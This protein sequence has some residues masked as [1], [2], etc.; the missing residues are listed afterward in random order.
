MVT[1]PIVTSESSNNGGQMGI[2]VTQTK[3]IIPRRRNDLLTRERLNH[4]LDDLLDYKLLLIAAPAGYGKTSLLIDWVHQNNLPVCWF[5]LDPLDQDLARFTSHLIASIRRVFPEFGQQSQSALENNP[6]PEL[7]I[8][9]VITSIVNDAFTNIKEHFV[10]VLDDFHAI[11]SSEKIN[12]F[13]SRFV[14]EVDENCHIVL[15][16]RTLLSLPNL[17]LMVGR[18]MVKGLSYDELAFTP[19][20][21]Q[22]LLKQNYQQSVSVDTALK[23]HDE[24]EGWITGLLL[25]AHSMWEGMK[26]RIQVARA[27]GV[28]LYEYLAQQVLEKQTEILRDFLLKTSL[29]EEFD[30]HLCQ[31]V[32]GD[33]PE[34]STWNDLISEVLQNNL[35]VLP[36]DDQGTWLRYHHLFRDFLQ[37]RII[38]EDWQT[39]C[40]IFEDLAAIHIQ[41]NDWAKAYVIYQRIGDKEKLIELIPRAG[42]SMLQN[43]QIEVLKSWLD[44]ID[45][46]QIERN[47][48]LLSIM[49]SID[50]LYGQIS[51]GILKL[52]RAEELFA[53]TNDK[54][55]LAL[56]LIRRS[57]GH[58]FLGQYQAAI[59]DVDKALCLVREDRNSR[60][61][62]AEALHLKGLGY[63]RLGDLR[64]AIE[65][66]NSSLEIFNTLD[67]PQNEAL[68]H[69]DIGLVYMDTGEH[70]KALKHLE[71]AHAYWNQ[72]GN[73][74]RKV[75]VLN[76]MGVLY[77]R[78]GNYD[79]AS[80]CLNEALI[81]AR[82]IGNE[83]IEAYALASIGDLYIELDAFAAAAE[84]FDLSRNIGIRIRHQRLI[85]YNLVIGAF[86]HWKN[87]DFSIAGELLED[88]A[89]SIQ[90][91]DS[92]YEKGLFSL[93]SGKISLARAEEMNAIKEFENAIGYFRSGGQ[94]SELIEAHLHLSKAY[95]NLADYDRYYENLR[96]AFCIHEET[97]CKHALLI[98]SRAIYETLHKTDAPS[99]LLDKLK[100]LADDVGK[101]IRKIPS[102]RQLI[103]NQRMEISIQRS[104]KIT[105]QA[106][107]PGQVW[108]DD[109]LV[110]VTEWRTQPTVRELFFLLLSNPD[111]LTKEDVGLI[112][113][114]DSSTKQLKVQ[115][116]NAVYRLRRALGKDIVIY[117]NEADIYR[118]NW[119]LDYQYDVEMFWK[120]IKRSKILSGD[121][122]I[123]AFNAAVKVFQDNYLSEGEGLWIEVEREKIWKAY[124]RA[125][126]GLA[127][128]MYFKSN[129]H[130]S[131]AHIHR[132]L[133]R[134]QCQEEAHRLAMKVYATMGN[135]ADLVRQ[136]ET[137][138]TV[139]N[140]MLGI[141]PSKQTEN[142]FTELL[143]ENV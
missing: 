43:R 84:A 93:I 42:K 76:N 53:D 98:A 97:G 115:F 60:E 78:D 111:G 135:Q 120:E 91:S 16:S 141:S 18:S 59:N 86:A 6:G 27:S 102:Q 80:K 13:V 35:F 1:I 90:R 79:K 61:I 9:N 63:Y 137:C 54:A 122:R 21:I 10:I 75:T 73:L 38:R 72:K 94:D 103:R 5:A 108:L 131:L 89:E 142:L 57:T 139:L 126:L 132:V 12:T 101:L 114:P 32:L 68:T 140:K 24:S 136:Y 106:L 3:I 4:F 62:Y 29:L 119:N 44:D 33:A 82:N 69:S 19:E 45:S 109:S 36:V 110:S 20:E 15:S 7:D 118:F 17:P 83:R 22:F 116:K 23:L 87:G 50:I 74:A 99:D 129:Y 77:H 48:N 130:S 96:S 28:G 121:E 123:E 39:V 88:A 56:L 67:N 107:G 31:T 133:S 127:R 30:A 51:D 49:G 47:P 65:L 95:F 113:W 55:Q 124:L 8:E 92:T 14:G 105:I 58:R 41:K 34:G 138:K 70:E 46:R 128:L 143:M 2:N 11:D 104:P 40:K 117:D 71:R 66:L 64:G 52:N 85:L 26:D 125:E 134:D 25:S 37:D 100:I 112:L 81:I